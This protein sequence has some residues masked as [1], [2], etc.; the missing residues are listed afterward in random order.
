LYQTEVTKIKKKEKQ[1]LEEK[2]AWAARRK[3]SDKKKRAGKGTRAKDTDERKRVRI[4]KNGR[5]KCEEAKS[6]PLRAGNS[7]SEGG[8]GNHWFLGKKR[9]N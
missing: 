1:D 4:S 8:E 6:L 5:Q 3:L 9:T 2:T 7:G